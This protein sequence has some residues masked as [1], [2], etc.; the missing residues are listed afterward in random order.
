MAVQNL[1]LPRSLDT[2]DLAKVSKKHVPRIPLTNE[3]ALNAL[4]KDWL[5][6]CLL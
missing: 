2:L 3:A 1:N 4:V 5:N 6:W